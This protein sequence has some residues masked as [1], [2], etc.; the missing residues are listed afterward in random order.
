MKK[1]GKEVWEVRR[2]E[3]EETV[4]SC[5][6]C[7]PSLVL[8]GGKYTLNVLYEKNNIIKN[9]NFQIFVL[10]QYFTFM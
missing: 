8:Q 7:T 3:E 4:R 10:N 2:K 9:D 5:V 6:Q 1:E